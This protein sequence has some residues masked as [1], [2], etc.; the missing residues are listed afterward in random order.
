MDKVVQTE[1]LKDTLVYVANITIAGR[2]KEEHDQNFKNFL[3]MIVK[4]NLTLN[5]NKTISSTPSITLLGY[6]VS[7]DSISPD[8]R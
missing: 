1:N 3:A 5:H 4:Y 7:K 2:S 6:T 8:Q